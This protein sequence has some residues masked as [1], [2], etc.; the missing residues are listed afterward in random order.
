MYLKSKRSDIS[1]LKQNRKSF[2]SWMSW[3]SG[4]QH[5]HTHNTWK[6]Y[7][8]TLV[9]W[10]RSK[11]MKNSKGWG[12]IYRPRKQQT[13]GQ[14]AY[15]WYLYTTVQ[16][17]LRTSRYYPKGIPKSSVRLILWRTFSVQFAKHTSSGP[18]LYVC[19]TDSIVHPSDLA[20]V[21]PKV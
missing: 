13:S 18:P 16:R 21:Q 19:T 4:K 15:V 5:A 20:Y 9:A 10:G 12:G 2:A 6:H 11:L 7:G 3:I 8:N 17:L 14:G 1:S